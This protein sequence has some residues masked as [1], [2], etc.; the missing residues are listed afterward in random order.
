MWR[1]SSVPTKSYGLSLAFCKTCPYF[2]NFFRWSWHEAVCHLSLNSTCHRPPTSTNPLGAFP[3]CVPCR[4]WSWL[5]WKV[6]RWGSQAA[7]TRKSCRGSQ[8]KA[9]SMCCRAAL[10]QLQLDSMLPLPAGL[11]AP[12]K[13]RPVTEG[14]GFTVPE[15]A[16]TAH[17]RAVWR[18]PGQEVR[19]PMLTH[20][21]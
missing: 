9:D 16:S 4:R 3:P 8:G 11:G 20:C 21:T 15:M 6:R 10:G 7:W 1:R 2:S 13:L 18:G 14:P 5:R 19:A 17:Q 12:L